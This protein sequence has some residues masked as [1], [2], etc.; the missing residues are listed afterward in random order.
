MAN[1][2]YQK[3]MQH[4][5]F[6]D[7][8]WKASAGSTIKASLID[9]AAYTVDLVNH[10]FRNP[11]FGNPQLKLLWADQ[12]HVGIE[13]EKDSTD[14][15]PGVAESLG[16]VRGLL[17]KPGQALF[18]IG[19]F[20]HLVTCFLQNFANKIPKLFVVFDDQDGPRSGRDREGRGTLRHWRTPQA[21]L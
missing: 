7:I 18:S 11:A 4:F 9:S 1:G 15:L 6:G 20:R 13:H 21:R 16:Y 12:Y 8:V 3:G 2:F 14:P 10:E 17:A 19:G 5:A